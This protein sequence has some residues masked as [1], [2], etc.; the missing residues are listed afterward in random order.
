[1]KLTFKNLLFLLGV[2]TVHSFSNTLFQEHPTAQQTFP[3]RTDGID[4]ELPNFDELFD[5]VKL[6]SPL[7]RV[8]LE[9][10]NTCNDHG[11]FKAI[12]DECK[13]WMKMFYGHY[14][15]LT[16]RNIKNLNFALTR[17]NTIFYVHFRRVQ[18]FEME[19]R[20]IE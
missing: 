3:S 16:Q 8:A 11:G 14:E 13:Y 18:R 15:C 12:D 1:M 10:R 9:G 19:S 4:I 5:R 2:H 6:V 17:R 7:A 20:R